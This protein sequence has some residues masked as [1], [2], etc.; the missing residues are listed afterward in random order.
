[1]TDAERY[2][3]LRE[4]MSPTYIDGLKD[5][6]M[7]EIIQWMISYHSDKQQELVDA[8]ADLSQRSKIYVNT[9]QADK[10]IE[11]AGVYSW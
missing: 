11:S 2:Q 8:L 9:S 7:E 6:D 3:K 10:V 1:M 4:G 5:F